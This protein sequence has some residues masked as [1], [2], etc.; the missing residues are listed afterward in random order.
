MTIT[1]DRSE[2]VVIVSND[3]HIGP[4]LVEDLRAYCPAEHLED[5]DRFATSAASE[6]D[7]AARLLGGS[8][9]LD[10]PNLQ[11][12][13][14]HDPAARLADYDY[15]GIAA[16]VMFHGSMNMEPIPF[17]PSGLGKA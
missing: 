1:R 10:H 14:H 2:P 6:R 7:A 8:G 4:R 15:D 13:G 16:G 5:F 9:Y 17:I 11:T 12:P 3:T